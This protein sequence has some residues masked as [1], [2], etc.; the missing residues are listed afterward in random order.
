M[1]IVKEKRLDQRKQSRESNK[2]YSALRKMQGH[3]N[4]KNV[5]D[6][7]SAKASKEHEEA[8]KYAAAADRAH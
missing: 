7:A 2:A 8:K 4:W 1:K 3:N 5:Y 6:A